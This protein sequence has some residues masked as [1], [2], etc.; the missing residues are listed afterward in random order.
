[1][2][3]AQA[4]R[5]LRGASLRLTLAFARGLWTNVIARRGLVL[6]TRFVPAERGPPRLGRCLYLLA[7]GRVELATGSTKLEFEGPSAFEIT[8]HQLEGADGARAVQI[9]NAGEPF[10][11]CEVHVTHDPWE[12]P[13]DAPRT[14]TV[15]EDAFSMVE[16]IA[17]LSREVDDSVVV[18]AELSLLE[19]L[20]RRGALPSRT[21]DRARE[22]IPLERL[23][24]GVRRSTERLAMATTLDQLGELTST[25]RRQLDRYVRAFFAQFP[26]VGGGFRA[27]TLHLRVKLAVLFLSAHEATVAEVADLVGYGSADAMGRAF[28]DAGLPAPS[29]IQASLRA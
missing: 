9:L 13:L 7:R 16:F 21:V 25:S 27:A 3:V 23:W 24:R 19:A 1:V 20:A 11:A 12:P 10:V 4:E 6:D 29:A 15:S 17:A 26:I 22:P 18:E 2:L 28:R 14:L 5:T 8:E